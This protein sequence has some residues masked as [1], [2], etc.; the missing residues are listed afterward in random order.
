MKNK[1]ESN[2]ILQTEESIA[3]KVFDY[4]VAVVFVLDMVINFRT[5][6]VN[7]RTGDEIW[8]PRM[9]AKRYLLGGRFIIDF[10]SAFP[11]EEL[12]VISLD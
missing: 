1:N 11:L 8:D 10:L 2:A 9:I 4:L 5:T 6:F 3:Y 12:G 7:T